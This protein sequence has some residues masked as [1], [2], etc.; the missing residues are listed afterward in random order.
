MCP[1]SSSLLVSPFHIHLP[2]LDLCHRVVTGLKR[3][4]S[5]NASASCRSVYVRFTSWTEVHP[6]G[7]NG[8]G[9]KTI[10]FRYLLQLLE[11]P[12]C[13]PGLF[14]GIFTFCNGIAKAFHRQV[15]AG[16]FTVIVIVFRLPL[17][18]YH[19]RSVAGNDRQS[20]VHE[21]VVA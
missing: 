10:R 4:S 5:T 12:K 9:K 6:D 19:L 13:F 11:K 2:S 21:C 18:W 7:N 16:I 15:V 1:Q 17:E 20:K 8:S 14:L 3:G